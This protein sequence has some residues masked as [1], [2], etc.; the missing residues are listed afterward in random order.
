VRMEEEHKEDHH[1]EA[2]I[3]LTEEL[4]RIYESID[5]P[6]GADAWLSME[7]KLQA[8][9]SR[10]TW[11]HRFRF[12]AA[13]LLFTFMIEGMFLAV[14]PAE[15]ITAYFLKARHG[16]NGAISVIIGD[17][18]S[19]SHSGALTAPPP[20][21]DMGGRMESGGASSFQPGEPVPGSTGTREETRTYTLEETRK[22]AAFDLF[23][24]GEIPEGFKLDAV[25]PFIDERDGKAYRISLHYMNAEGRFL[26]F[27]QHLV[28]GKS[29]T[30]TGVRDAKVEDVSVSGAPGVLITGEGHLILKWLSEDM[31]FDIQGDLSKKRGTENGRIGKKSRQVSHPLCVSVGREK[32]LTSENGKTVERGNEAWRGRKKCPNG[33]R[34]FAAMKGNVIRQP[35]IC[36]VGRTMRCWPQKG[37]CS[38]SQGT[39]AS[40]R[41]PGRPGGS[42]PGGER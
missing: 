24:P 11:V 42:K 33:L 8:S 1:T 13:A 36:L 35:I 7:K 10:R 25:L 34:S 12:T 27:S 17:N 37:H 41:P 39:P 6:D 30:T 31:S 15:A 19:D 32:Y 22:L 21:K 29:A 23:I 18:S 4:R 14:K 9:L 38:N 26:H 20:E 5:I 28:R 3:R 2:D 16:V 40:G